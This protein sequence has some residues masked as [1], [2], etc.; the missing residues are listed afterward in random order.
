[1]F[2]RVLFRSYFGLGDEKRVELVAEDARWYLA[3]SPD[4]YDMIAIDL[5]VTGH[6][7]FFTTTAEFF[8]EVYDHLTEDGVMMMNVLAVAQPEELLGPLVRTVRLSFPSTF[9]T[10][11][12]NFIL[13][14]SR[15]PLSLATLK[16]RLERAGPSPEV[17][18]VARRALNGLSAASAGR[19]W[20]IFTDD[21]NDVEF[22][23]FRTFYGGF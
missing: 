2:R 8:R 14:A 18:Q 16:E 10:G 3:N 15:S 19:E 21:L 17:R 13:I 6:I 7:P 5:Y 9:L 1:M 23:T 22:R 4:R 20:P 11:A 12:G